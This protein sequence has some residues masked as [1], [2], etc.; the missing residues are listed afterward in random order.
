MERLFWRLVGAA[1]VAAL[2]WSFWQAI[3]LPRVYKSWRTQ[4]CVKVEDPEGR[5]DCGNLPAKYD[6][7][8]VE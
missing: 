3:N 5:Y 2:I 6:M 8:W 7:V 1:L 4:Q